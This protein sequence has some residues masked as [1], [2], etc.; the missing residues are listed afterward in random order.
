MRPGHISPN[1]FVSGYRLGESGVR[2]NTARTTVRPIRKHLPPRDTNW[3]SSATGNRARRLREQGGD[4]T[5]LHPNSGASAKRVDHLGTDDKQEASTTYDRSSPAVVSRTILS[6][7]H[8]KGTSGS[9]PATAGSLTCATKSSA[10]WRN[11]HGT[12]P[13]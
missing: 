13:R 4:D 8:A 10:I 1:T 11:L 5:I 7:E 6:A 12:I 2:M 3:P 9:L